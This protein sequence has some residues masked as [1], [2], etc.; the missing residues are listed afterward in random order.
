MNEFLRVLFDSPAAL[1]DDLVLRSLVALV[2]AA[3]LGGVTGSFV[4]AKRMTSV[5]GA[6]SH[7]ALGGVG[8]AY[9]L[10]ADPLL[11]AL[12]VAV[13][14]AGFIASAYLRHDASL[15]S[16]LS[17]TWSLGMSVGIIALSISPGYQPGLEQYL[18]GNVFLVSREYLFYLVAITTA[19][20][21]LV[22]MF[23]PH[24]QAISFDEEFADIRG[25]G[26]KR[27]FCLLMLL[28]CI[29]VVLLI[30]VVGIV[31]VIALL[32]LPA[33][34]SIKASI[35]LKQL[36]FLSCVI[37]VVCSLAGFFVSWLADAHYMLSLPVGPV[38]VVVAVLAFLGSRVFRSV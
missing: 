15:D 14:S 21:I 33:S 25:I 26:L 5:A 19:T 11:G 9:F 27:Y 4:V 13:L 35:G 3:I 28:V 18:F 36:I 22:A 23:F 31:L 7:A 12:A 17:V 10:G 24:L 32:S 16:L 8:I 20:V 38:I 34:A 1:L 37:S 6:I 30:Q 29:S 2:F